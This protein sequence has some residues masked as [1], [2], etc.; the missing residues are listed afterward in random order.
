MKNIGSSCSNTKLWTDHKN[1][2]YWVSLQKVGPR[3]A[4]WQVELPQYNYKLH[5][6]PG[7]QNKA[8]A[9]SCCP[10]YNTKNHA[11]QH[12]IVLPLDHFV[13][14]PPSLWGNPTLDIHVRGLGEPGNTVLEDN[15]DACIKIGQDTHF[16]TVLP[17]KDKYHLS[18]D[19]DNYFYY[20]D[21]LIVMEDNSL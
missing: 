6:K 19:H 2:T 4:T 11:N 15:L 18:L 7:N 16:S 5:H 13:G 14:M 20:N 10:D 9:L 1:L 3:A 12:L 17:W 8:D 21:T